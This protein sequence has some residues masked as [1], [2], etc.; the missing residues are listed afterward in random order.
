MS[1]PTEELKTAHKDRKSAKGS[2][3]RVHTFINVNLGTVLHKY[4]YTSRLES[5]EKAFEKFCEAQDVIE[6]L[7][8]D[9]DKVGDRSDTEKIYYDLK[10]QLKIS[11]DNASGAVQG[12]GSQSVPPNVQPQIHGSKMPEIT[13]DKFTGLQQSWASFYDIFKALVL[14]NPDLQEVQ[15]LIYLKSNLKGEP[16]KLVENLPLIATN[17]K[18][19]LDILKERYENKL[20]NIYS[21]I[22]GLL[23]LPSLCKSKSNDFREFV[24]S[25]KQHTE[26]LK[27]LNVPIAQWDLILVY[28]LSQ[29]L[30]AGTRR[31]YELER[32]PSNLPTLV[33]FLTFV[34][35]RCQAAENLAS[36]EVS[37]KA[38]HFAEKRQFCVYCNMSNHLLFKCQKF[39]RLPLNQRRQFIYSKR[40][41][42]KCFSSHHVSQC[43]W[44]NCPQC[45]EAHNSLLHAD[46]STNHGNRSQT[47]QNNQKPT[48]QG[49]KP[50]ENPREN[51]PRD[52]LNTRDS[53]QNFAHTSSQQ[54]V[55]EN[56]EHAQPTNSNKNAVNSKSSLFINKNSHIL[57][58]TAKINI[59]SKSGNLIPARA[60][61]DNGSQVSLITN[62]L[63]RKLSY[64]TYRHNVSISGVSGNMSCHES[65]E[66][67]LFSCIESNKHFNVTCSVTDVITSKLPQFHVES[68][69]LEIPESVILADSDYCDPQHVDLLLGADIYF[70][71]LI[72][73]LIKLGNDLPV[74]Q[75]TYLGWVL[76][77]FLS[78][79]YVSNLAVSEFQP[80]PCSMFLSS[81]KV[82]SLLEKFWSI[83]ELPKERI[84][85]TDDE[86]SESIFSSTTKILENGR[87]QIDFPLKTSS[88]YVKLGESFSSAKKRFLSLEKR[89]HKDTDMFNQ[90]SDFINEY[91]KLEHARFIPLELKNSNNDHK[92]FI[93]HHCVIRN[94]KLTTKLRVVFD[95]SMKSSS[96]YSLNDLCLK[97]L[98]VQ[99]ELFDILCRFRTFQYT[100]VADLEKMF[101]QI[102]INPEHRFLQNILWRSN[103]NNDLQCIELSTVSYGTNFAPYVATRCLVELSNIHGE[104]YPDASDA[105]KNQTYV[106]DILCGANSE[107]KL[108]L[109]RNQLIELLKLGGFNLHKWSSNSLKFMEKFSS[110]TE[111]KNYE[112]QSETN[113]SKILGVSW[114]P[115][116]DCFS[117]SCPKHIDVSP[118]TKRNVL[119]VIAQIYDPLSFV[120]PLII[121]AKI[122]MQK[123]WLAKLDWDETLNDD[124]KL[125]WLNF[126]K[127]FEQLQNLKISRC[128]ILNSAVTEIQIHGFSDASLKAY[129]CCIYL[130]VIYN[131]NTVSSNLVCAKSRVSPLRSITLP[132][133][134][135]CSCVLL[136]RLC[137]KLIQIFQNSFKIDSV[138]L[139]SD[140]QI[141]LAWLQSHPSKWNIFVSNRVSVILELTSNF[142]WRYVKSKD[143]PADY[144]SRGLNVSELINSSQWWNGPQFLLENNLDLDSY[145]FVAKLNNLP[146]QRKVVLTSVSTIKGFVDHF[147]QI[148]DNFSDYVKLQRVTAFYLRFIYNKFFKTEEKFTES[149]KV[150]ELQNSADFIIRTIQSKYFFKEIDCL[151]TDKIIENKQLRCLNPFFDDRNI[152]RVGGRLSNADI[153]FNQK[154]PILLPSCHVTNLI[155]KREHLRLY[156]AGPQTVLSNIRLRYWPLNGL[157]SI[158]RIIHK[159]INCF[160]FTAKGAEQIMADLPKSRVTVARPFFRV[161]VDFGGPFLLKTS[162]L[163]RAPKVKAYIAIF[164]CMVTKCIHIELVS[165]L[166][167]ECFL[168][169]LKR[170]IARRGN[171]SIIYSDNATNFLGSSNYLKELYDFFRNNKNFKPIEDF[172]V[173][174]EI[175]WKFI[176]PRSPHWGGIWEA[177]IKS[178]KHHILRTIGETVLNFEEFSTVLATIE[179]ILNSRPLT[180]LSNNPL[181]LNPLTP[182][183]F[184]IGDSLSAYPER[185]LIDTPDNRLSSYQKCIKIKQQFWKRWSTD[186]LN[187][188]QQRPKWLTPCKDLKIDQIVLIKDDNLPPLKWC[189]GRIM[190]ILL[191]PDG[192]VR[193]VRVRTQ[194]GSFL[195]PITKLCPLP[196]NDNVPNCDI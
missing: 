109:L 16:F 124:L 183:H 113:S 119:S 75:N 184:L 58:A 72:P 78:D 187:R 188:L 3:T 4:E 77:G 141:S 159:C 20:A 2:I 45:G 86:L 186:Y 140:S 108:L 37:R 61:L 105:I 192:K 47:F 171:P 57:L 41:C 194:D 27:N 127:N 38:S 173:S 137:H 106:D 143:N 22:K 66:I 139:W 156:H 83:E 167:T 145:N 191:S 18:V 111:S 164:V 52:N 160:K 50:S 56:H 14:D 21:H 110:E 10:T 67:K 163:R 51:S 59:L 153:P 9:P 182:G 40:L 32:G 134:E 64:P 85:S 122:F 71:L 181:D 89:L 157:R 103:P 55:F 154:Y 126:S 24:V 7:E 185:N 73:G 12:S 125:E 76:G 170:F 175:Q 150:V 42:F 129:G 43:T 60:V 28:T 95:A 128:I 53:N 29:K 136:S 36:P 70:Q 178:A 13:I 123:L 54:R 30:D 17:L 23:E 174:L 93:P 115:K 138:N 117:I 33:D 97:G 130:R 94:D 176:P 26:S 49:E 81:N 162:S 195:R 88:E 31:A 87:F 189:L 158:K 135:L 121:T 165:G 11:I 79:K 161:G 168:L 63:V 91:I 101:R 90:Y 44:K 15:K 190:E 74:L 107:E 82:D 35:K 65:I 133:L 151:K 148:F 46:N 92:Y 179:S 166:S 132:R 120:A 8:T 142:S 118:V 147:L 144:V 149:L 99:P 5:L 104:K 39:C 180:V 116:L 100:L 6:E 177:A 155:L 68:Q 169:T 146:E 98:V 48:S 19:A 25:I 114:N 96:G 152:M 62:R 102:L 34:E 193:L 84:L 1:T 69:K 112:I 196:D 80:E 172:L 131:N